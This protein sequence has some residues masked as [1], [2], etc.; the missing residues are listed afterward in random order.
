MRAIHKSDYSFQTK[1]I[2]K[3]GCI[4][5]HISS[6]KRVQIFE[7]AQENFH[8]NHLEMYGAVVLCTQNLAVSGANQILVNLIRGGLFGVPAL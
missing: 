6:D 5:I 1:G 4:G 3:S 8:D 2:R 7:A